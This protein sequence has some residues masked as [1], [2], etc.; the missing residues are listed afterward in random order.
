MQLK[1]EREAFD[2]KMMRL[3][4][5]LEITKTEN[6]RLEFHRKKIWNERQILIKQQSEL[7]NVF[8]RIVN[9]V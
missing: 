6:S 5:L 9:F 3:H 4:K 1:K 8:K 2:E 7:E